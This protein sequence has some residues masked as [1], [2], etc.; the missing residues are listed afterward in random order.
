MIFRFLNRIWKQFL[1]TLD[2]PTIEEFFR[3]REKGNTLE[4]HEDIDGWIEV[5]QGFDDDWWL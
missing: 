5:P 4:Y 3:V 2:E 1:I